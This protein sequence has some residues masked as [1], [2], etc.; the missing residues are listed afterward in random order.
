MCCS[1]ILRNRLHNDVSE[2]NER[3]RCRHRDYR[4]KRFFLAKS[5]FPAFSVMLSFIVF[6]KALSAFHMIGGVTVF[7]GIA[8]HQSA[9]SFKKVEREEQKDEEE[10]EEEEEEEEGKGVDWN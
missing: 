10:G 4:Q 5:R 7:G 9:S 8:I 2:G 6:G 1:S 3:C